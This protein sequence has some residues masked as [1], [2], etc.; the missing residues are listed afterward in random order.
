MTNPPRSGD[1]LTDVLSLVGI[2][3]APV[4]RFEAGS[5]A[6]AFPGSLP[7][8][9]GSV[10]QGQ[11]W[12]RLPGQVCPLHLVAGDCY[13]LS[14]AQP[15]TLSLN[16]DGEEGRP[17][18]VKTVVARHR[19]PDGVVRWGQSHAETILVCG[20]FD[21]RANADLLLGRLPRQIHLSVQASRL[22]LLHAALGALAQ[23]T[24]VSRLGSRLVMENLA[25]IVLV[26]M[27]RGYAASASC[28]AG[29]WLGALTDE[30]I[31]RALRL[32]HGEPLRRWTLPE[33]AHT[34]G[35]SRSSFALRFKTLVGSAPLDY[36][37]RWRMRL[38]GQELRDS[39]RTISSL[40]LEYGYSSESA[41]SASFKRALGCSPRSYRSQMN[42][43]PNAPT[44]GLGDES[45]S[46]LAD[47]SR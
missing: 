32:M 21:L 41:F 4:L 40:A 7:L 2:V 37:L 39:S 16:S 13:L 33:L 19:S 30:R 46:T 15:Y 11:A 14:G 34:A 18:A 9:L 8:E 45:A 25:Q 20:G 17:E 6:L 12:L 26:E 36:L 44:C 28:G 42:G 3:N 38:A 22:P 47:S 24:C 35:M 29:G 1:P 31:D 5:G 43:V 10:I 27:L 23:E